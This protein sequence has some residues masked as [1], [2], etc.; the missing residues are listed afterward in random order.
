MGMDGMGSVA[1]VS[2]FFFFWAAAG[3]PPA[4]SRVAHRM[5]ETAV[6]IPRLAKCVE[7]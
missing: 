2:V 1:G 7:K 3:E 5:S 6:L 4:R